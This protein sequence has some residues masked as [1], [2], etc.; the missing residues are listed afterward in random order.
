MPNCKGKT[1][2]GGR[3]NRPI[4]EG[5]FCKDH[6][7]QA[8]KSSVTS[9]SSDS[10]TILSTTKTAE[11]STIAWQFLVAQT[12]QAHVDLPKA[13]YSKVRLEDFWDL[14]FRRAFVEYCLKQGFDVVRVL[15]CSAEISP[16]VCFHLFVCGRRSP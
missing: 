11:N 1:K 15:C 8:T 7:S 10:T 12:I 13:D 16:C 6:I 14:E 5:E 4:V 9:T 2:K 3:C